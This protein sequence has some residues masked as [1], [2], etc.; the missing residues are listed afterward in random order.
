MKGFMDM[1]F[2]LEGRFYLVDWKSNFLGNH[3]KDYA[4]PGL[5][6]AMKKNFYILQYH[7]YTVALHQY[8]RLRLPDYRYDRHFGGVYYIFLRGVNVDQGP[9]CGIFRDRPPEKMIS[10]LCRDLIDIPG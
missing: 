7:I 10:D 5:A 6:Q 1:V 3:M 4:R 2:Q 9:G 8:L